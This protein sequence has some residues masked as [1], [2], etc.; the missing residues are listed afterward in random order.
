MLEKDQTKRPDIN[1]V[2]NY[3]AVKLRIQKAKLRHKELK[4]KEQFLLAE[5]QIRAEYENKIVLLQKR[6]E[7]YEGQDQKWKK[8]RDQLV[9][10]Y[11]TFILNT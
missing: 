4:L 6:L 11:V 7:E 8:E 5:R 10:F 2:L 3:S 9:S 1:Q